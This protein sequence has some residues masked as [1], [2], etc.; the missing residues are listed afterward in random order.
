[1]IARDNGRFG[2]D[3]AAAFLRKKGY[4]ITERN[5]RCRVGEIDIIAEDRDFIV[6]VEVKTRKNDLYVQAREYV[7]ASKQR[8]IRQTALMYLA[9][10]ETEKQPR[11]DVIEVYIP[12]GLFGTV[13]LNHLENAF[14]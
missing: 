14:M 3:R 1:M 11:F 12:E 7:T 5:Y 8:K 9:F 6:F 2:E 13:T 4:T 10:H